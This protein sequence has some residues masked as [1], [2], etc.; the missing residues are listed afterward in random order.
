VFTTRAHVAVVEGVE[1]SPRLVGLFDRS[2]NLLGDD[3][4]PRADTVEAV[5]ALS[6]AVAG[7]A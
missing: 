5:R 4:Q 2:N 6:L 3:G 7:R 1:S